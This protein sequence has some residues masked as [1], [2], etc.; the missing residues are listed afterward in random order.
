MRDDEE[1]SRIEVDS[2]V[3]ELRLLSLGSRLR[4]PS[5]IWKSEMYCNYVSDTDRV[6]AC[7][8]SVV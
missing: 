2:K 5:M 1:S 4:S 7:I 3:D 6:S 8:F